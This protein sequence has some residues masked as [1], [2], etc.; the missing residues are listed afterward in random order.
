LAA[1]EPTSCFERL[2]GAAAAGEVEM[3][4]DR[5]EPHPLLAEWA[6]ARRA[7]GAGRA[8]VVGCGLGAGAEYVAGLDFDTVGFDVSETAARLSRERFPRSAVHYVRR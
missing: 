8:G 6:Q 4:W 2:Y 5:V 3:P 1:G 7:A